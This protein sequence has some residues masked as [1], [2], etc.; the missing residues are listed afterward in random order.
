MRTQ[1]THR[2][3]MRDLEFMGTNNFPRCSKDVY[4]SIFRIVGS[5]TYNLLEPCQLVKEF[6]PRDLFCYFSL[7]DHDDRYN[8]NSGLPTVQR[9]QHFARASFTKPK[10]SIKSWTLSILM[11]ELYW[12]SSMS[13]AD[14]GMLWKVAGIWNFDMFSFDVCMMMRSFLSFCTGAVPLDC[15]MESYADGGAGHSGL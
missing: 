3:T 10:C 8:L 14:F 6:F 13:I 7:S 11:I 4:M 5:I 9:L 1:I 15:V 12:Q 2:E